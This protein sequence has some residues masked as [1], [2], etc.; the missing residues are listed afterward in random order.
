MR[1]L[2]FFLVI[3][4]FL[5]IG[6]E[7]KSTESDTMNPEVMITYPA[8][9]S[10]IA[11]GQIV[12]I[13]A[14]AIDNSNVQKVEF[15]INEQVENTDNESPYQYAWDTSEK[16][17]THTI[18]AKAYDTAG[19]TG[20]SEVIN[21]N[22]TT[23]GFEVNWI[24]VPAGEYAYGPSHQIQNLDY[25]YEILSLLITNSQYM[26]YLSTALYA[27]IISIS[28][29]GVFGYYVGD[30]NFDPG[31][32][33]FYSFNESGRISWNDVDFIIEEGFED[34]PV[35]EISWFGANAFAEYYG[36]RLPTEQEWEK[37]A[38]A[39]N[40]YYFPWGNNINGSR[41]NYLDSGDPW[42]EGTT[43]VG[44]YNGQNY[45]GFQTTDSPSP[46]GCYDMCGNVYDWT[47]SWFDL[48]DHVVRGGR[49][50]NP[51]DDS[52]L[53]TWHRVSALTTST[54]SSLG[55]RLVR[56]IIRK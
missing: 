55:F 56:E 27:E 53:N 12:T 8:D 14:E 54:Q 9:G 22:V 41:A 5:M 30:D 37:A 42:D 16:A 19:N 49:Y 15:M 51:V 17:G 39:T 21:V 36:Y 52:C 33:V 43:P 7:D 40:N 48:E 45:Q 18:T 3:T 26:N 44:F 20:L 1:R 38:R 25:D 50:Q 23:A 10:N 28:E 2:L 29:E 47:S 24:T 11:E 31:E 34:H 35:N 46:Y 4:L 13:I 6:C 32:Y